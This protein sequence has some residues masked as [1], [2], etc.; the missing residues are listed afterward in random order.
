[1]GVSLIRIRIIVLLY[2]YNQCGFTS[3]VLK[4]LLPIW[5]DID[6]RLDMMISGCDICYLV[7]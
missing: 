6:I 1:M 5:L 3:L 2:K 7:W 4:S